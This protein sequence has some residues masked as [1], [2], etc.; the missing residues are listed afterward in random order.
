MDEEYRRQV[1]ALESA[2]ASPE[3]ARVAVPPARAMIARVVVTPAERPGI[4]I[5]VVRQVDEVLA[6]APGDLPPFV[7]TNR[8][9]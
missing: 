9:S 7:K 1:E 8:G 3:A 6:L 2:L 5:E 4:E